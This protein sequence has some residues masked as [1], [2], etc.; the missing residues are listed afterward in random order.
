MSELGFSIV[1]PHIHQWDPRTTPRAV[2]PLTQLFGRWPGAYRNLAKVV[3]P[4]SAKAFVGGESVLFPYLPADYAADTAGLSIDTVVH[5][6]AGWHGGGLLGPV[7]ETRWLEQLPFEASGTKLG[8]IVAHADLRNPRVDETLAAHLAASSKVRGI[9]HMASRHPGRGVMAWSKLPHLFQDAAFLR[10]F[11]K[12]A[13]RKL[14]FDAWVYS[15]QLPDVAEL[16]KR[17]PETAIVLD[18][19]GSP[20]GAGGPSGSVGSTAQERA[21]IIARWREDFARLRE[22]KNVFAKLSGLAMPVIGFGYHKRPAPPSIDELTDTFRPFVSHAIDVFGIERAFFAS[23]FPMDKASAP[24]SHIF[25]AYIRLARELGEHAPRAL[26]RDNALRFY[27][28]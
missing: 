7:G 16:A 1:D 22:H 18:H 8:A 20:V 3:M 13:A 27:Q 4:P 28:I 14:R 5:V 10:G 15:P 24:A 6:E 9:R 19:F 11:E 25:G 2:S 23:N 17:F 21:D 26:L 12:L